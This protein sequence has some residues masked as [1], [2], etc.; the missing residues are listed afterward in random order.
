MIKLE[1][2]KKYEQYIIDRRRDFHMN[3]E[4]GFTEFRTSK[5]IKEE[6]LKFGFSV[7]DSIGVTGL[8]GT[9][10]GNKQGKTVLLR[11]DIDALKMQEE[12]DVPYKSLNDGVMHSCGHEPSPF[13]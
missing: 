10:T 1:D 3:P 12:N 5:I 2:I 9:L 11:A 4:P 7:Q 13:L 6:L 8:V